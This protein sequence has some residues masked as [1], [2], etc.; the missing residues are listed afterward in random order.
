MTD[1]S[2][3][4][5]T[6]VRKIPL[7]KVP[8][9]PHNEP[10]LG[11]LD[12]FQDGRSHMAIVSRFS[13]ER[14]ASVKQAVKRGLTQRLKETF[15]DSDS[16]DESSESETEGRTQSRWKRFGRR[17]SQQSG[18]ENEE[19][20]REEASDDAG[21]RTSGGGGRSKRLR[22]FGTRGRRKQK[23]TRLGDVDLEMGVVEGAAPQ[24]DQQQQ[25]QAAGSRSRLPSIALPRMGFWGNEQNVPADAVLSTEGA[26]EVGSTHSPFE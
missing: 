6:P 20:L 2:N 15:Q 3:L 18:S 8:L 10:L 22:A 25:Q 14:A 13:V 17:R 16:D 12:K 26:E 11:I 23:A 1:R 9:V 7:N 5:A 24:E 21:S 19:T 4:E